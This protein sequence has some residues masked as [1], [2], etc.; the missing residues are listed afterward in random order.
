[1]IF[2]QR[3]KKSPL[4]Y[5]YLINNSYVCHLKLFDSNRNLYV[6]QLYKLFKMNYCELMLTL[7]KNRIQLNHK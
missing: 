7:K 1:M 4:K 6:P 5:M 2:S 3:Y